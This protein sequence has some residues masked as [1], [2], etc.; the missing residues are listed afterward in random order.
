[1]LR[2]L[3]E[4]GQPVSTIMGLAINATVSVDSM[5]EN[6]NSKSMSVHRNPV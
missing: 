4:M 3:V 5:V 1:M 6:V 2:I